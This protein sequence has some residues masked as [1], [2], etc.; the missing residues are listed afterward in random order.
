[1]HRQPARRRSPRFR[2]LPMACRPILA[3]CLLTAVASGTLWGEGRLALHRVE[4]ARD[5]YAFIGEQTSFVAENG[6]NMMNA[7]FV[8]T[9]RGVV[10]IDS[11]LTRKIAEEMLLHIREISDAPIHAVINTHFHPDHTFGNSVFA[12]LG[13]SILSTPAVR[14]QLA[15]EGPQLIENIHT[16]VAPWAEGTALHLPDGMITGDTILDLGDHKLELILFEN[17]HTRSD[18]VVFD[19]STGVLFAGDLVFHGS[20]PATPNSDLEGWLEAVERLR[21]MPW[22]VLVP[23]H[24]PV[25]RSKAGLDVLQDYLAWL[26]Q[27][28]D[29][30]VMA[31]DDINDL[32]AQPIPSP[33]DQLAL[34]EWQFQRSVLKY[35]PQREMRLFQGR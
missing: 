6:G 31:G 23:G 22:R 20:A 15:T 30:S 28:I 19:R 21:A 3:A 25:M 5:T 7:G 33:F 34:V 35:F 16:L 4:V 29:A 1:M 9:R 17:A 26:P 2:C 27:A 32:L 8:V 24:G 14:E 11:G 10:L 13:A 12:A 18:M